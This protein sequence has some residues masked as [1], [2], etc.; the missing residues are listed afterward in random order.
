MVIGIDIGGTGVK[1]GIVSKSGEITD[2]KQLDTLKM[3]DAGFMKALIDE[4]SA[5][6]IL[7]RQVA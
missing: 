3:I 7:H 1:L 6:I 5:T 2:F 4:I